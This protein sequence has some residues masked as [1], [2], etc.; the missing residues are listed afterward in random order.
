ME[1]KTYLI[2]GGIIALIV[3][4]I[5]L[6]IY[7]ESSSSSSDSS[8]SSSSSDPCKGTCTSTQTCQNSTGTCV[9][10]TPTG[11]GSGGPCPS[12]QTCN[13]QGACIDD[14][15]ICNPA[16]TSTQ[17]CIKN[18]CV[19]NAT[20]CTSDSDC[21]NVP[22]QTCNTATGNCQAKNCPTEACDDGY[23]CNSGTCTLN[24]CSSMSCNGLGCKNNTCSSCT[25]NSDCTGTN[26]TCDVATGFCLP[27]ACNTTA[28]CPG[29]V[30]NC[31]EVGSSTTK[32]CN[33]TSCSTSSPC[34]GDGYY[35]DLSMSTNDTG[36]CTKIT[37][38]KSSSDCS[39]TN[40]CFD[41][42][43]MPGCTWTNS[44][45][46]CGSGKVCVSLL[47]G[48][49]FSLSSLSGA[50]INISETAGIQQ[51]GL[52]SL[53]QNISCSN[54]ATDCPFGQVCTGGKCAISLP[55]QCS[56]STPCPSGYYCN[57]G[58]CSQNKNAGLLTFRNIDVSAYGS[59]QDSS[60]SGYEANG[61][62]A[63]S[64][65]SVAAEI[66]PNIKNT[67]QYKIALGGSYQV[68]TSSTTSFGGPYSMVPVIFNL[69]PA[70]STAT[71]PTQPIFGFMDVDTN[72]YSTFD[73]GDW[74][75]YSTTGFVA[76]HGDTTI[77]NGCKVVSAAYVESPSTTIIKIPA[78]G[79]GV[80]NPPN[81][82]MTWNGVPFCYNIAG[83][84]ADPVSGQDS[85]YA[86]QAPSAFTAYSASGLGSN[87]AGCIFVNPNQWGTG[88]TANA[89]A[90]DPR[91]VNNS[92]V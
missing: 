3:V 73:F 43:C 86:G 2:A 83:G 75:A 36:I 16:C 44:P 58:T 54:A 49:D 18:V 13:T 72:Y 91:I 81:D 32:T 9:D 5:V 79:S 82:Y 67:G 66:N 53:P 38:C 61:D 15:T 55:S 34:V 40:A 39:G 4:I 70:T 12:G 33:S 87:A 89:N 51:P 21:S 50:C 45:T 68:N 76:G 31:G 80:A 41:G 10:N 23:F 78:Y 88:T 62:I 35:C 85:Q 84:F 69:G 46:T 48:S 77:H 28:D 71:C 14:S 47:H 27:P 19:D 65:V 22:N 57:K 90:N 52:Y 24:N 17:S 26:Y 59:S 37:P 6:V 25:Q 56:S 64:C 8:S 63:A 42:M 30:Y 60:C 29:T 20:G 74:S 92:F 7:F 11:C 1:T